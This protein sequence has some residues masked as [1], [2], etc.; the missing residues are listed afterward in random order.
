MRLC[1]TIA[2]TLRSLKSTFGKR[3]PSICV[4]IR[5]TRNRSHFATLFPTMM[6]LRLAVCGGGA[7]LSRRNLAMKCSR[8]LPARVAP[9]AQNSNGRSM[10]PPTGSTAPG[11]HAHW[12]R[13]CDAEA[14]ESMYVQVAQGCAVRARSGRRGRVLTAVLPSASVKRH[15]RLTLNS[16]TRHDVLVSHIHEHS[17]GTWSGQLGKN[18]FSG[19]R[20][21]RDGLLARS[22]RGRVRPR[23]GGRPR[24]R[25]TLFR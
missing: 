9:E 4:T 17:W 8:P 6:T 15:L 18:C 12:E 16:Q 2:C 14:I 21:R 22:E 20:R 13:A 1:C 10:A 3:R 5:A 11:S 23:G 19:Q 7:V 24:L 25:D